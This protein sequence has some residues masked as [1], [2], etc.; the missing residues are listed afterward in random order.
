MINKNTL[1]HIKLLISKEMFMSVKF[2]CRLLFLF[3]IFSCEAEQQEDDVTIK[4]DAT[5]EVSPSNVDYSVVLKSGFM[6]RQY[7]YSSTIKLDDGSFYMA[8]VSWASFDDL[9]KNTKIIG[10]KSTD[11]GKTWSKPEILQEN[12]ATINVSNPSLI[13]VSDQHL[14]LFFAAKESTS[15]I[16]LYF[17]E[18]FDQGKSWGSPKIINDFNTGYYVMNNDR[19]VYE[20]NRLWVPVA[21]PDGE[22]F[23]TYDS[24]K[25][26]CYYSDDLGVTWK[27]T[28]RLK[29]NYALME[30]CITVLSEKE[31]LLNIRTKKGTVLFARSYDNGI[32]WAFE[33]SNLKSPASPQTIFKKKNSDILFIAWNN[34]NSDFSKSA[35]N[36]TPLSIGYSTDKGHNWKLIGNIE[37][38]SEYSFSYPSMFY[39]KD[40]LYL[41][42]YEMNNISRNV[43][44]KLA[45][46]DIKL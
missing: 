19:V 23:K 6:Q 33:Y 39:D 25:V 13:K 15:N 16:N 1:F 32:N 17:K 40:N 35:G 37:T 14:L 20:N 26:F 28:V 18:S 44:I 30:P 43:S 22:I 21:V 5:Q 34:T 10:V 9:S 7:S 29:K 31:L 41:N 2:F 4:L 27:K 12:I 3:V 8:G 42:Y 36:R 11:N 46:I 38:A 45:K 24:Q